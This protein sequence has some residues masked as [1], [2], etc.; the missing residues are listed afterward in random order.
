MARSRNGSTGI[1]CMSSERTQ[2]RLRS[3]ASNDVPDLR[4]AA[5]KALES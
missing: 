5:S 2:R 3:I 4:A 1:A